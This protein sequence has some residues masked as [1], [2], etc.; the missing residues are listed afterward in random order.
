M[1]NHVINIIRFINCNKETV[2]EIKKSV[3]GNEDEY[4]DFNKLIPMPD[5]IF[6]GNLGTEERKLY[7]KNN[8]YD[9]SRENWG[10][11][12]NAYDVCW[13]EDAVDFCTAWCPVHKIVEKPSKL[14][15][16]I[17]MFYQ[18]ADENYGYN[19]GSYFIKNGETFAEAFPTEGTGMAYDLSFST[20]GIDPKELGLH[21]NA[22]EDTYE[23]KE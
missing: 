13:R 16:K 4:F 6:R 20:W 19:V 2:D 10:T 5:Y 14:F 22:Q 8:W 18:W 7:G 11:K 1:P 12:W 17:T 9:W 23:Y 3:K 21:Y 15:P